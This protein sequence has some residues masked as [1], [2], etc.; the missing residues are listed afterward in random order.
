MKPK[1][2]Y[3]SPVSPPSGNSKYTA[4]YDTKNS[5]LC[6]FSFSDLSKYLALKKFVRKNAIA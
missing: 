2:K 5:T 4:K 6:F 1:K 3:I